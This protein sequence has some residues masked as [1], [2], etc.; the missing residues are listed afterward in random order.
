MGAVQ[1]F[2]AGGAFSTHCCGGVVRCRKTSP[3]VFYTRKNSY[4]SGGRIDSSPLLG[5]LSRQGLCRHITCTTDE[6][7]CFAFCACF[8]GDCG[9]VG[10][11]VG[12]LGS[13]ALKC[14][15]KVFSNRQGGD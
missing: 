6:L 13:G 15:G 3:T 7:Q 4:H 12:T 10:S 14:R 8:A 9:L 11:T 5:T 2:L 1:N